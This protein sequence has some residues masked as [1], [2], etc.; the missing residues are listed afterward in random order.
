[1]NSGM[2]LVASKYANH[3]DVN[4][5]INDLANFDKGTPSA[6]KLLNDSLTRLAQN[7][8][9]CTT[10]PNFVGYITETAQAR[11]EGRM[12]NYT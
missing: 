5:V 11:R 10:D 3:P 9:N 4:Q 6:L 8:Y 1:M 12:P 2:A 7:G